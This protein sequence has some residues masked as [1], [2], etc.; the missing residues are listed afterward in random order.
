MKIRRID[1]N[2]EDRYSVVEYQS[3]NISSLVCIFGEKLGKFKSNYLDLSFEYHDVGI[4]TFT[5]IF[6]FSSSNF[7]LGQ[8]DSIDVNANFSLKICFDG[9]QIPKR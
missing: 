7:K 9:Q 4:G 5:G 2:L 8:S 3:F 1:C 6:N